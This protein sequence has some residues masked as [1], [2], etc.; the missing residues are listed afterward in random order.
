[1]LAV[2]IQS[3][4][5]SVTKCQ[6]SLLIGIGYILPTFGEYMLALLPHGMGTQ[7]F[8]NGDQMGT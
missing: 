4:Y 1:M 8:Q 7:I 6:L 2:Y 5:I 3:Q